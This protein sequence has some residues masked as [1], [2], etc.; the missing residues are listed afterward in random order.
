MKLTEHFTLEEM[1]ATQIR[2]VDNTPH[3]EALGNL[4]FTATEMEE[5]RNLLGHPIKI[6]SAYRSPEVN[7][8]VGG[9]KTSAHC[10]GWA[11]DFICPD[12]GLPITVCKR[13]ALSDLKFD[14]LIYEGSWVHISFDPRLRKQVLTAHFEKGKPTRY[15]NGLS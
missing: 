5:V 15:T 11:V 3:D 1:T 7:K 2:G 10:Q 8:A 6:N 4:F 12:F 9:S 14:Q 13:L